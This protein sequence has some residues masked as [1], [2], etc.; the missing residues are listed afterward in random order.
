MHVELVRSKEAA[1]LCE[2]SLREFVKQAWHVV[3]PATEFSPG[4]HIDAICDHLE[5]VTR[6]Q[7]KNL[8]I[9]V[10]PRHMKSL[11][12]SVFWPT[13]EWI[14][15]PAQ[16]WLFMSYSSALSIR[17]SVKCRRLIQSKW[18]Q[19]NFGDRYQLTS[20]Q[21]AKE[22][23]ETDKTGHRIASSVGGMGTGEGGDR[24]VCFPHDTA[25]TT[26]LGYIKIG[27]IVDG[28][29]PVKVLSFDH[30]SNTRRW[31]T[32][33]EY[34]SAPGRDCVTIEMSNGESFSCTED[35]PVYA[36][37]RGYVCASKLRSGDELI[38]D[39][40]LHDVRSGR[41]SSAIAHP[42]VQK[43]VL[44]H[45][46]QDE[47]E[48]GRERVQLAGRR[49]IEDMS[50]VQCGVSVQASAGGNKK[51]LLLRVQGSSSPSIG[52]RSSR[53][54]RFSYGSLRHMP[55]SGEANIEKE[56]ESKTL[57][58]QEVCRDWSPLD[59]RWSKSPQLHSRTRGSEIS[60]RIHKGSASNTQEGWVLPNV[61]SGTKRSDVCLERS[62]HRLQHT[63]QQKKEPNVFVQQLPWQGS[64]SSSTQ[65]DTEGIFVVRVVAA[66]R[67][68]KVYN[69]R[70]AEDHNYFVEGSALVHNCDD[71]ISAS[72]AESETILQSVLDWWDGTMASRSNDPKV[73]SRVIVM[74]RLNELDLSGHVLELGGFEHLVLPMRY[75]SDRKCFT[76]IN[77]VDP[78]TKDGELLWPN[79]FG[80]PEAQ[81]LEKA[82]GTARAAGQLQQ[83]P[84]PI[85]GGVI[86]KHW[87]K[88]WQPRGAK[89][90]PVTVR[91]P[92]GKFEEREAVTV[93]DTFG[94]LLQSW[95]LPFKDKKDSDF[96]AG[97]VVG[98]SG[99]DRYIL[100]SE[101]ARMDLPET[102][103]AFRRMS[104][105]WPNAHL[106]LVEGKANGPAVIQSLR[107]EIGGL[108][109][110]EPDG[111]KAARL[112][113]AA[114]TI[115]SG[116]WY[117]PHPMLAE[118]VQPFIEEL[119]AFPVGAN[120]DW[121][122]C[123]SQACARLLYATPKKSTLAKKPYQ[124]YQ[125]TGER[126]WM[127]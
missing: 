102:L 99:A 111:S 70:V 84:S 125:P 124:P 36:L 86:K 72:D 7:I 73:G 85:G 41:K 127:S 95:D 96:V 82:L 104:M 21:N 52:S 92:D 46:M 15:N 63:K 71:P 4:W 69:I 30:A 60:A 89:L 76:S 49:H 31:Q 55:V 83:R 53:L 91:M 79:R 24:I 8:L 74:Q 42:E 29:L 58:L 87:W 106:K 90:R 28:R 59:N 61:S 45:G 120:D 27:E 67:P 37:G 88:Y 35:H 98:T 23:Y 113:A 11:A 38:D 81:A 25:V 43:C 119:S 26:N 126:E 107:H 16:R 101:H 22:K 12:V 116:N 103:N 94:N 1:K 19:R 62:S 18:Y 114:P 6:G 80:E 54:R 2:T 108:V 100:D 122:D 17:D 32:I 33:E 47:M 64:W 56:K 97:L 65:G 14:T 13:W 109:E 77:F 93:P 48:Q 34:E 39:G 40:K 50:T 115:E 9:N 66:P 78:R 118:W 44:Q 121:C 105:R 20:D 110:V 3:E 5:S 123:V 112:A 68:E 51:V 75:E 57:L 10:P 117:L